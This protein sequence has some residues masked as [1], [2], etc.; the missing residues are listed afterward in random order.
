V[1]RSEVIVRRTLRHDVAIRAA[2]CVSGPHQ[3]L[4]RLSP[5]AGLTAGWVEC[6]CV[7]AG[8]GGV[9]LITT[10]F[11]PRLSQLRVRLYSAGE[12]KEIILEATGVVRRVIMTDRRPAY[13]LG[14]SFHELDDKGHAQIASLMSLLGS[15]AVA[16]S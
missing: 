7:D 16:V 4:V 5:A 15:D 3:Q 9:G 1:E 8:L 10:V 6:D 2:F 12:S 11:V 14:I 13:H